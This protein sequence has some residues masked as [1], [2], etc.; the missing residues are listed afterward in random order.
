MPKTST[1]LPL[2][3]ILFVLKKRNTV[4]ININK[5]AMPKTSTTLPLTKILFVLK[6]RNTVWNTSDQYAAELSSGLLNSVRFVSKM[7]RENFGQCLP[8][9]EQVVDGNDINRVVVQHK[10]NLVIIEALWATPEK[11]NELSSLYPNVKWVVRLHSE[12]PF[13]ANEGVAME[14]LNGYSLNRKIFVATNSVR[15]QRELNQLLHRDVL[16]LPNCYEIENC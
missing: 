12:V 9:L 6:K 7:I 1:T 11:L 14:W 15:A 13:L 5:F 4:W 10:P 16:Y 3:K 2:T 8:V